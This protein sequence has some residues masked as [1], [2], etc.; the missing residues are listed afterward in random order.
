MDPD[1]R[2]RSEAF[3]FR[4]HD[5]TRVA[6][7][8]SAFLPDRLKHCRRKSDDSPFANCCWRQPGDQADIALRHW[9]S[10]YCGRM[11][12]ILVLGGGVVG[13]STAMMLARQGHSVTVFEHDSEP[14]PGSPE[15]AWRA[16]E[17]RGVTQFRQPH[18]PAPVRTPSARRSSARR[19]RSVAPRRLRSVGRSGDYARVYR[20][21]HAARRR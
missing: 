14:L 7:L 1:Q 15:E 11:S 9:C 21:S 12:R 16:W 13:L 3:L 6:S 2:S 20:R 5:F 10:Y 19:A 8:G 18:Y 17:R 4:T